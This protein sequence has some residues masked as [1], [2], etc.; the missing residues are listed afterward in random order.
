MVQPKVEFDIQSAR[1]VNDDDV[2]NQIL[3]VCKKH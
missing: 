3:V 1:M 2:N